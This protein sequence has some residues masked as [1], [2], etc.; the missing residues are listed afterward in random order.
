M[1][2]TAA[3]SLQAVVLLGVHDM[4]TPTLFFS[5]AAIVFHRVFIPPVVGT[6]GTRI[7]LGGVSYLAGQL[8]ADSSGV[9]ATKKILGVGRMPSGVRIRIA[10]QNGNLGSVD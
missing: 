2:H 7:R 9:N 3:L 4:E 1:W 6:V 5:S 8:E 10:S